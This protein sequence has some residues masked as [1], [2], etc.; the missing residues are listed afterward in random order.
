M[1]VRPWVCRIYPERNS[2]LFARVQVWPTK[3]AFLAHIN[4]NCTFIGGRGAGR[5]CQ[6]TCSREHRT[7]YRK[8]R[9]ARRRPIFATVNL[10]RGKLTMSV[11]THELFHATIAWAWRVQFPLRE[12][13]D[14][15]NVTST[16]ER[17]T[18]A[19]SEMCRQFM[20]RALQPG[21]PYTKTDGLVST[22]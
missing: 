16:E 3:K 20:V 9:P 5:T 15:E 14:D 21:G 22:S 11:V 19:H 1:T 12:L 2:S 10:W 4:E 7:L 13:T 6:G 17:I 8:N 18:Y